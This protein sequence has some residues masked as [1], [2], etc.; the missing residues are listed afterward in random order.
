MSEIRATTLKMTLKFPHPASIFGITI[1]GIQPLFMIRGL[2][3][4]LDRN[5][6]TIV[7]SVN[8]SAADKYWIAQLN[9]QDITFNPIFTAAEGNRK[10]TPTRNEF[11]D[12]Y[13]SAQ[14]L[15]KE[16]LPLA[17]F[18]PHTEVSLLESYALVENIADRRSRES[19][20]L[21]RVAPLVANRCTDKDLL[22]QE[23][24]ILAIASSYGLTGGSLSLLA[25]LSCLY[26]STGGTPISPGRGV[27]H[28]KLIY[29]HENAHNCL[30]DL[31]AL[32]FILATSSLE[33]GQHA[34]I[35]GD[36]KLGRFWQSLGA[37]A[38][39]PVNDRGT[40]KFQIRKELLHRIDESGLARLQDVFAS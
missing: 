16:Y 7:R 1:N 24:E 22:K 8:S 33:I 12:L 5:L 17:S 9:S 23:Q 40:G 36:K 30:S 15:I 21:V 11:V 34:F 6:L 3:H 13:F 32:E 27:L 18:I 20:F 37:T 10:K 25:V 38:T 2:L 4:V 31:L 26:E 35:T 19:S 39:A 14:D 28:P 29:T